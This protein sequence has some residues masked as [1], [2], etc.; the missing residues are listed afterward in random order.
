MEE[1]GGY[2]SDGD[3]STAADTLWEALVAIE[4]SVSTADVVDPLR[5]LQSALEEADQLPITDRLQLLK[6]A[7]A[8]VSSVL[9]GL[10]GL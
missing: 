1:G 4:E 5:A 2:A 9:E 8:T 3:V 10:D 7:E 6:Q